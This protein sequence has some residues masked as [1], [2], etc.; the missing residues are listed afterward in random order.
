V[1]RLDPAGDGAVDDDPVEQ[2]RSTAAQRTVTSGR[3]TQLG[4]G[5]R[6]E[7]LSAMA[8]M[9]ARA[10]SFDKVARARNDALS[11]SDAGCLSG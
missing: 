7:H 2:P 1:D 3:F 8:P 9:V 6:P 10:V 5:L 11:C 4:M